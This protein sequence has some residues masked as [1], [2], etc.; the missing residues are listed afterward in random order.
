VEVF[1]GARRESELY[2]LGTLTEL[3]K[4]HSWLNVRTAVLEGPTQGLHG[5]LPD[6]VAGLGPWDD[7]E[8][9]LSGPPA[10]V[11]RGVRALY[12][13]GVAEERIRH[14]LG[15]EARR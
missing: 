4:R 13:V 9:Y 3:A 11:R 10:M 6:V 15:E 8:A 12:A 7:Y 1:Y 5:R 2:A 14:D